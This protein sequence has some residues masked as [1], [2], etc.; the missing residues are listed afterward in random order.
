M[1]DP[2]LT[3]VDDIPYDVLIP[4]SGGYDSTALI[5]KALAEKKTVAWCAYTMVNNPDQMNAESQ[6]RLK[7]GS[8]LKHRGLKL[9][10]KV[11]QK[12]DELHT[13]NN[14]RY[15]IPK[16]IVNSTVGGD[17]A[18]EIWLGYTR[19]DCA[20]DN[21][22]FE[23]HAAMI[24][25]IQGLWGITRLSACPDIRVP[26]LDVDKVEMLKYY[27]DFRPVMDMIATCETGQNDVR[28]CNCAKCK[29]LDD[30]RTIFN[31]TLA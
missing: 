17:N 11:T 3:K 4:W 8:Y 6:A 1:I 2:V 20:C 21:W 18:K 19:N 30:L 16:F 14:A 28:Y 26:F 10:G 22:K 12:F 7:I 5:L 15:S 25:V 27:K 9:T 31:K 24:P 23:D 13:P 29:K